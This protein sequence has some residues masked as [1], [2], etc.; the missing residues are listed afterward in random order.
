M[1][2]SNIQ[3]GRSNNY[4]DLNDYSSSESEQCSDVDMLA[5]SAYDQREL[6]PSSLPD[7]DLLPQEPIDLLPQEIVIHTARFFESKSYKAFK[8]VSKLWQEKLKSAEIQFPGF[9]CFKFNNL[10]FDD[11]DIL[12]AINEDAKSLLYKKENVSSLCIKFFQSGNFEKAQRCYPFIQ[13]SRIDSIKNTEKL[14]LKRSRENDIAD[15]N[16]A[17]SVKRQLF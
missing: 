10:Q 8:C 9:T 5:Q 16:P 7:V 12:E 13:L 4:W 15:P 6:T 3:A 11:L 2:F 1:S 14:W 17:P